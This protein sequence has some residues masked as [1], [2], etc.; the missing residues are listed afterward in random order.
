MVGVKVASMAVLLAEMKVDAMA[1][2]WVST[3][4]GMKVEYLVGNWVVPM[5]AHSVG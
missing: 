2:M 1:D 3:L 5:V 4:V